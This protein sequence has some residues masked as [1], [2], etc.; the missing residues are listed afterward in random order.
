MNRNAIFVIARIFMI[1][2]AVLL[3]WMSIK[4]TALYIT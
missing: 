3:Y 1:C 4:S 2:V